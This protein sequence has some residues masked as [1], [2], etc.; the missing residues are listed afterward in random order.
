MVLTPES[1]CASNSCWLWSRDFSMMNKYQFEQHQGTC[2]VTKCAQ[3]ETVLTNTLAFF[4]GSVKAFHLYPVTTTKSFLNRSETWNLSILFFFNAWTGIQSFRP[5]STP[6]FD[7]V[8]S[9]LFSF[10]TTH[11]FFLHFCSWVQAIQ[12]KVSTL[13]STHSESTK[14]LANATLAGLSASEIGSSSSGDIHTSKD[15]NLASDKELN[16]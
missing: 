8:H 7:A 16:C 4:A 3:F 14:S 15:I 5:S 1:L 9:N 13:P 11:Y 10:A 12:S 2:D 6:R